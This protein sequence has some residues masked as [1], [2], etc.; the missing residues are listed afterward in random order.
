MLNMIKLNFMELLKFLYHIIIKLIRL[1]QWTASYM[2]PRALKPRSISTKIVTGIAISHLF[3]R[4]LW[5]WWHV[6]KYYSSETSTLI[7]TTFYNTFL[8][9]FVMLS[10][11]LLNLLPGKIWVVCM[12]TNSTKNLWIS[13]HLFL[14]RP[15]SSKQCS[16]LN[17]SFNSVT[18]FCDELSANFQSL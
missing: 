2:V 11:L 6:G 18:S 17:P 14:P 8:S 15:S 4:D 10:L 12:G 3:S 16:I 13:R 7:T 9:I 5:V 1:R